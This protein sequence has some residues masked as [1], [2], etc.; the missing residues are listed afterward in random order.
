MRYEAYSPL[1]ECPSHLEKAAYR[2]PMSLWILQRRRG[3]RCQAAAYQ[4]RR[5]PQYHRLRHADGEIDVGYDILRWRGH[6]V[7]SV[8]TV[9]A[10]NL[11]TSNSSPKFVLRTHIWSQL[12]FICHP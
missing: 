4:L 8:L 7:G 3:S 6:L 9:T 1:E 12:V 2:S 11:T 10:E 5:R